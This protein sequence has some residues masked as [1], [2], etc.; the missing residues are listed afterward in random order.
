MVDFY[1]SDY[2]SGLRAL[3]KV[4]YGANVSPYVDENTIVDVA[5]NREISPDLS[6]WL[7]DHNLPNSDNAMRL[8][9]G[10]VVDIFFVF[11]IHYITFCVT[12][13]FKDVLCPLH[14]VTRVYYHD[15]ISFPDARKEEMNL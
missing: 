10:Y 11:Y 15:S 14:L 4:G 5:K 13:F 12:Q 2:K 3:V 6:R 1:I 7:L 9:E 8:S